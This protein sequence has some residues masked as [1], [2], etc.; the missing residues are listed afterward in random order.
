MSEDQYR[1]RALELVTAWCTDA[2]LDSAVF[3]EVTQGRYR[4]QERYR[5][6]HRKKG[7]RPLPPAYSSCGDLGHALLWALGCRQRWVN[8]TAPGRYWQVGRNVSLLCA[9]PLGSNPIAD[10]VTGDECD[11]FPGDIITVNAHDPGTTHVSVVISREGDSLTTGDYGQP[12]G[13]IVSNT[14]HREKGRIYRG[15]RVISSVL[16]LAA[17]ML[18]AEKRGEFVDVFAE[19]QQP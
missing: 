12:H 17:A 4:E 18:D 8:R 13:K 16:S 1:S 10:L 15:A 2:S 7:T 3:A 19:E 6:Y 14:L 9:D 5:E 11:L